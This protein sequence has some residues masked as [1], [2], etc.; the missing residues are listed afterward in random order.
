M[1][2]FSHVKCFLT[3]T[4]SKIG[5]LSVVVKDREVIDRTCVH[6]LFFNIYVFFKGH[7]HIVWGGEHL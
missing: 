3:E 2:I 7:K 1:D 5:R 6:F 4:L